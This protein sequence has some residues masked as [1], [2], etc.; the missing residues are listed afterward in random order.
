[1]STAGKGALGGLG[2]ACFSSNLS[3][4]W[5]VEPAHRAPLQSGVTY[6]PPLCLRGV[7]HMA[8]PSTRKDFYAYLGK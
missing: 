3:G 8:D 5:L 1:M 7:S 2:H 6:A 4:C